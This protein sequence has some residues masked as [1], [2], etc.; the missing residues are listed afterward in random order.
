VEPAF[1]RR[2]QDASLGRAKEKIPGKKR[3]NRDRKKPIADQMQKC[4][5][6]TPTQL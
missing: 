2:I 5:L 4:L 3:K 1:H 6:T